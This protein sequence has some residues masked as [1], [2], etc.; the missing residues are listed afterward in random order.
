MKKAYKCPSC[1]KVTTYYNPQYPCPY[2]G[3]CKMVE[4]DRKPTTER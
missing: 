3:Q 1:G 4:W 2:C